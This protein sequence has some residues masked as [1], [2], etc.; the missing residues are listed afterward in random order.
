MTSTPRVKRERQK[1]QRLKERQALVEAVF[2]LRKHRITTD[3]EHE[4]LVLLVDSQF[5]DVLVNQ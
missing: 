5:A 1:Q 2:L 3:P 4:R